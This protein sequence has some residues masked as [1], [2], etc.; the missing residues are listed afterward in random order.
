MELIYK[1]SR[2]LIRALML[3]LTF[4]IT[5]T[6]TFCQNSSPINSTKNSIQ[7]NGATAIY[8]GMYSLNYEREIFSSGKCK[9]HADIGI[10][11]WYLTNISSWYSG[12]S[13]P[14]SLNILTGSNNN[15]FQLDFGLRYTIFNEKS[16]SGLNPFFPVMNFGY[17]F[18]KPDGKGMLL[19]A[20]IG[21]SGVGI[22]VGKAF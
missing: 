16:D 1:K 18:Q 7:I 3:Y 11:E 14:F 19:H 8:L 15:H 6:N 20:Y 13:F 17:R 5:N 12:Y 21:T 2:I 10:G 9:I 4:T 22:G